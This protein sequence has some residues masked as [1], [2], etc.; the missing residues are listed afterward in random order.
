MK[1]HRPP[2]TVHCTLSVV[3][4]VRNEEENIGR[5][6]SSITK[7]ADEIVIFDE[8]STD[9]TV[10]IA[11]KFGAKVY[12]HDRTG[13]VEPARNFA[14]SKATGDWILLLDADEEITPSLQA[15]LTQLTQQNQVSFARLPRQNLIFNQWIQHSRW[16]PDYNIRFFKK[17]A[18]TWDE[19]IHSVPM[20][21]GEGYDLPAEEKYALIHHHYQTISQYV[22]RLDRYTTQ[23]LITLRTAGYEFAWQDLLTK[24][25]A[26]FFSRYFAAEGFKDGLHGLALALLQSI[27]ELVLYLKAWEAEKFEEH[28]ISVAAVDETTKKLH[29]D[30][31]WW[32]AETF[33]KQGKLGK[34]ITVKLRRLFS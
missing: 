23:Q 8:R 22:Q 33:R 13:Y 20:T 19:T 12:P 29:R 11:K 31:L 1:K 26:E 2:N 16:W 7:I 25:S 4:A 14:I 34:S 17:G 21:R 6:L 32:L 30:L 24:P 15:Q 27:S 28:K 3:L 5:C 10:E 9:N 18:V